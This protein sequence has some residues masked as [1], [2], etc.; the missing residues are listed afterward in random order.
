MADLH[1]TIHTETASHQQY[2]SAPHSHTFLVT[3]KIYIFST[4][5]PT[6]HSHACWF[7]YLPLADFRLFG[8]IF[9]ALARHTKRCTV[10]TE[11][12]RAERERERDG[13]NWNQFTIHMSRRLHRS[14][15][16]ASLFVWV[17]LGRA[18]FSLFGESI[19]YHVYKC[20]SRWREHSS[21]LHASTWMQGSVI[22]SNTQMV[23]VVVGVYNLFRLSYCASVYP[24]LVNISFFRCVHVYSAPT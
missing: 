24:F 10:H 5:F 20:I 23:A 2:A 7:I 14:N 19:R 13:M 11:A 3:E 4:S 18:W 17:C 22:N 6:K 9:W 15:R 1:A 12:S 16:T 8:L 21:G